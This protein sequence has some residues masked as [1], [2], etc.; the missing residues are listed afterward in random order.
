M[1]RVES[2]IHKFGGGTFI[3]AG[4]LFLA[5]NL[6]IA[7]LPTPPTTRSELVRWITT[8]R[9]RISIANELLFFATVLLVPSFV[10]LGQLLIARSKISAFA[11]LSIIAVAIPLLAMLNVV[12]GRLVYPIFGLDLSVDALTLTFSL[13]FGGMHAVLLMFGAALLLFGV[14]LRG[15]GFN[16][17]MVP[18]SCVTG[19]LQIAGAYPLAHSRSTQCARLHKPFA[20]DGADRHD[21][22]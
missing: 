2:R 12:E 1:P 7:L 13:F 14:A 11:G 15:T 16:K 22:A 10:V 20:L 5:A 19:L 18:I 21:G 17:S 9:L 8:N 6:L 4:I 3:A